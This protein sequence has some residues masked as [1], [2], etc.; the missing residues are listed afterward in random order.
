[1][2]QDWDGGYV[3]DIGYTHEFFYDMSPAHISLALTLH[4]AIAPI[5][6]RPFTYCD[7]GCGQGLT[8]NLLAAANPLGQFWATDFNPAHVH[9]AARLAAEAGTTN[10]RF[11]DHD[12]ARMAALDLPQ[13]DIVALHGV[14]SWVNEGA[15]RAVVDF[16]ARHLKVGGVVYV[17]YNALPGW[18]AAMPLRELMR[19]HGQGATSQQRVAGGQAIA[20]RLQALGAA[21]FTENPAMAIKL[22]SLADK[23][24]AY[25]AHEYLNAVFEP[26]YFR[27]VAADMAVAKLDYVASTHI[28]DNTD[29]LNFNEEAQAM[30]A[31][32]MEPVAR[33][34]MR[35]FLANRQFRRDIYCRGPLRLAPTAQT[36][37]ML[38][39]RLALV[40]PDPARIAMAVKLPVGEVTLK[41]EIYRPIIAALT[42][43]PARALD[44]TA[45]PAIGAIGQPALLQALSMLCVMRVVMA[46]LPEE[47]E[48]ARRASTDLFNAAVLARAVHEDDI[49]YLASPV[50]GSGV[51]V[52]RFDQLFMLAEARGQ[53]PVEFAWEALRAQ[54]QRVMNAGRSLEGDAANLAALTTIWKG[55]LRLRLPMLRRLGVGLA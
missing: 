10:V 22:Q 48:A 55:F 49:R 45:D 38:R 47:G 28:R 6:T 1:M 25:L 51:L 43:G 9:N 40:D 52:S 37:A 4:G 5:Q 50:L 39:Q 12:F 17:S 20:Q 29:S 21:C 32:I 41:P 26:S 15:R 14:W 19:Q 31:A 33:E 44:L 2:T 11:F 13:F 18:A 36:E 24:V 34:G 30:L 54:G 42:A 8:A 16:I 35:D 7:L 27:Q 23:P 53:S 46:A 3:A